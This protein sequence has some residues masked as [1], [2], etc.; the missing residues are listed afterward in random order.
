MKKISENLYEF[1][2]QVYPRLLWIGVGKGDFDGVFDELPQFPDNA[3]AVVDNVTI[4]KTNKG[5][6]LIRFGEFED[7]RC[8]TLTHEAVHATFSIFQYVD[9]KADC[10]NQEPF[11]YL[12]GWIGKCIGLT[13]DELRKDII[14]KNN[15]K[16]EK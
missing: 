4:A 2:P 9:A 1:D 15:K 8:G 3:Y 6:I 7:I 14:K 5:G 16:T 10:D 13:R 12:C 11:A